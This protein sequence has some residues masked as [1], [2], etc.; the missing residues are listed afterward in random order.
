MEADK[1]QQ[2]PKVPAKKK[3]R[4]IHGQKILKQI[5]KVHISDVLSNIPSPVIMHT[6]KR[7]GLQRLVNG[8]N[9]ESVRDY[10]DLHRSVVCLNVIFL[11][12]VESPLLP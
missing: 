3:I 8:G 7:L 12:I 5:P 11:F 9:S 4:E 10:T 1:Y 2:I 6:W